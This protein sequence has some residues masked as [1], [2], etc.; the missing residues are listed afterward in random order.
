[1]RPAPP[2][3][4]FPPPST[5]Q[6][7]RRTCWC[8]SQVSSQPPRSDLVL[9]PPLKP[10]PSLLLLTLQP[11]VGPEVVRAAVPYVR[12]R[13]GGRERSRRWQRRETARRRR[14]EEERC[15]CRRS[16]VE[17]TRPLLAG[18]TRSG[19]RGGLCAQLA[20]LHCPPAGSRQ[21]TAEER[22]SLSPRLAPGSLALCPWKDR[23][24]GAETRRR[25]DFRTVFFPS[26]LPCWCACRLLP[27]LFYYYFSFSVVA[28]SSGFLERKL[29]FGT[30]HR[31]PAAPAG[32]GGG[33]A[34][35][36]P[37]AASPAGKMRLL[38]RWGPS[39]GGRERKPAAA[40]L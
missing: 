1:M 25:E 32:R 10:F 26:F 40:E 5:V 18:G 22:G 37:R 31:P 38:R 24:H 9:S 28:F 21:G 15:C 4:P 36:A 11:R 12:R 39:R 34:T 29:R 30:W 16:A 7:G 3:Q 19:G 17:V 23:P 13:S 35:L 6:T 27:F 2:S 20:A 33:T 14:R 8:L